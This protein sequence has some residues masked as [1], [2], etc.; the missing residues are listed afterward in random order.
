M[1]AAATEIRVDITG[2]SFCLDFF[3]YFSVYCTFGQLPAI[4]YAM[5]LNYLF[6]IMIMMMLRADIYDID[7]RESKRQTERAGQ[8]LGAT[9]QYGHHSV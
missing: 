5:K 6:M 7:K 1:R 3:S 4:S 9:Q 2:I 8:L